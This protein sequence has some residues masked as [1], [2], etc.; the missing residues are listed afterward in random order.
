MAYS[1]RIEEALKKA[2]AA[3]GDKVK[4]TAKGVTYEGILMPRTEGDAGCIVLKLQSGYNVGVEFGSGAKLEKTG[5]GAE[6]EKF[7]IKKIA[8][9]GLP[10]VALLAT[11]GTIASRVDYQ[12]GAVFMAMTPEEMFFAVPELADIASLGVKQLSNVASEDM[13]YK[14]WQQMAVEAAAAING[15]TRGVVI[16]HGTDT[17]HYS[18]AAVSFM[19]RDLTAPVVFTGSQRSSDRGSSDTAMNLICAT[20]VALSDVAEVGICMHAE[21][22]DTFCHFLRGTKARKMHTS[23]RDAFRPVNAPALAKVWQDGKIEKVSEYRMRSTGEVTADTEF[24]PR[25]A[26]VK[27]YPGSSGELLEHFVDKGFKGIVIEGTG[28]GHAPVQCDNTWLPAIKRA[29]EEGLVIAMASQCIYGRTH[30]YVYRNLRALSDAGVLFCSDM[31]P[32][33][34]YVKLG[35]VLAHAQGS[36]AKRMM[37]QNVAGEINERLT[38][39]EFLA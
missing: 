31:L 6:L 36:E 38:E 5:R 30:A 18:S 39:K 34:A 11:G 8:K 13:S 35:W 23:R 3:V 12:T 32:E 17:M 28:L 16:T 37:L 20:H 25:V 24:E 21:S 1:K 19:L 22:G 10:S 7:P 14:N 26:L 9:S 27:A 2:N 33:V 29:V 15:G 4:L